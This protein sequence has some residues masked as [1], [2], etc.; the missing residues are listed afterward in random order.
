MTES[1]LTAA[2]LDLD[3]HKIP[4]DKLDDHSRS[5]EFII[6]HKQFPLEVSQAADKKLAQ[7]LIYVQHLAKIQEEHALIKKK[8]EEDR[9]NRYKALSQVLQ[10]KTKETPK[11]NPGLYTDLVTHLSGEP[12]QPGTV[13]HSLGVEWMMNEQGTWEVLGEPKRG[14]KK[15]LTPK[16]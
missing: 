7:I 10:G 3:V 14:K 12:P 5:L 13:I 2:I 6:E 9:M 16:K 11:E 8:L 4:L 15:P 1:M